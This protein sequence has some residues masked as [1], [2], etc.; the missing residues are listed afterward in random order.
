MDN[1][2]VTLELESLQNLD[3]EASDQSDGDALEV[4]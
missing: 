2:V 4:V 3:C 1:V